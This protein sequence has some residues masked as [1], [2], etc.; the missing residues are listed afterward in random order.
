MS[1]QFG[2]LRLLGWL[3][4]WS[5]TV[6]RGQYFAAGAVLTLVKYA[7][8][9]HIA[10]L[11]GQHWRIWDYFLST[12]GSIFGTGNRDMFVALWAVALPFFW[13]GIALTLRRLRSAGRKPS[14]V[15]LFFA[16]VVNLL[17]FLVLCLL[18]EAEGDT[19][20]ARR[21]DTA[22]EAMSSAALG[23]LLSIVLALGFVV[24]S[25]SGL[26]R[27]GFGLFLGVPFS[28]GFVSGAI[29]N[30]RER[31]TWEATMGV[32]TFAILLLGIV[33]F[34]SAYEGLGCLLMALPLAIPPSI[35][36]ALLAWL[37]ARRQRLQAPPT[38][39]ALVMLPLAML[40]EHAINLRPP[41]QAVSTA[42]EI[43]APA[44]VVWEDV[45]S[46][47]PLSSPRELLFRAG[48]AYPTSAEIHGHGVGAVR[49]CR[50]STG[51]FVEPIT[52]WDEGR[53]LGFDVAAQPMAMRELSPWE[54]T[55][56]HLAHDYMR[57]RHGQFLLTPLPGGHTRLEG[58]TW[59]QNY[60]WPQS[61]WRIWSDYIVHRIHRR[62][63]LQVK[64]QAERAS[65]AKAK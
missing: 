47:P 32:G 52:T 12:R 21:A 24:L 17:F 45:V 46:F 54:I 28:A 56:P 3:F 62:V 53:R 14:W 22:H 65:A 33:L 18:P 11:Y 25:V 31:R 50:F 19:S 26:D 48:I 44:E 20:D 40:A 6:T 27:Y 43:N 5:G 57:S 51:D 38:M 8:D 61:Y 15:F 30:H 1:R 41:L 10:S 49:Y 63:L 58:T 7:I 9:R 34:G 36:G 35:A 60:F 16:P 55:P 59:Y 2:P 4:T 23:V 29:F 37:I 64:A 13:A 39:A 42:V